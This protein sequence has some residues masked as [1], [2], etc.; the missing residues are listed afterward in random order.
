MI[1]SLRQLAGFEERVPVTGFMSRSRHFMFQQLMQTTVLLEGCTICSDGFEVAL[2]A[3]QL[4]AC[5]Y[6]HFQLFDRFLFRQWRSL[7]SSSELPSCR[8]Q[9]GCSRLGTPKHMSFGRRH[10][11]CIWFAF[12][13][14]PAVLHRSSKLRPVLLPD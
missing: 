8:R 4:Y 10:A 1:S 3:H 6:H 13:W 5:Q 7:F 2:L 9:I 12:V 11:W 14:G